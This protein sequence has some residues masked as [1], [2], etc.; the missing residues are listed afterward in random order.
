MLQS[1]YGRYMILQIEK[2]LLC[3]NKASPDITW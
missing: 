3:E 1:S 2:L